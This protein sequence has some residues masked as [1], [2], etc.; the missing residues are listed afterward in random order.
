[1]VLLG[2]HHIICRSSYRISLSLYD[3]YLGREGL[4]FDEKVLVWILEFKNCV[5][6]VLIGAGVVSECVSEVG[7]CFANFVG[8]EDGSCGCRDQ[9]DERL[10]DCETHWE[11]SVDV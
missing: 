9:Q 3:M 6:V 8:E 11:G 1:M 7:L 4:T 5:Y 10:K 2:E